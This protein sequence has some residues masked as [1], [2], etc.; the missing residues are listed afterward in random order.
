[1]ALPGALQRV[2]F[3]VIASP[4]FIISTPKLVIAQCKAGVV[5]SMPALNARP[6][7][8]LDEWLAEITETLAAHDRVQIT[9]Q[10]LALRELLPQDLRYFQYL[11]SLTSPPCT[12]GVLRLVRISEWTRHQ[13]APGP[14]VSRRAF[15]RERRYPITHGYKA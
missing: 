13:A 6:A 4:M 9:G 8:Q 3:P 10:G 2:A 1:M 12:E 15:G 11:G 5:G 7:S 14:K